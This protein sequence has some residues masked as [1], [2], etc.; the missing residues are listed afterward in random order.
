[1]NCFRGSERLK[2]C[3]KY[4]NDVHN[5]IIVKQDYLKH[6]GLE[7]DYIFQFGALGY[8]PDDVGR[9]SEVCCNN[10]NREVCHINRRSR[11][12]WRSIPGAHIYMQRH[13]YVHSH[14]R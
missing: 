14:L 8:R 2:E 10:G 4:E 6:I 11:M 3:S 5:A 1:M 7:G 13:I 9:E 12:G